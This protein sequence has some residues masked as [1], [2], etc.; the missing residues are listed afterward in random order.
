[1]SRS[2]IDKPSV[3][4][5]ADHE[6]ITPPHKLRRAMSTV[7]K[8]ADDPVARAERAL[9]NVSD[10]FAGW[11]EDECVRL[12]RARNAVKEIG[13]GRVSVEDAAVASEWGPADDFESYHWHGETFAI[14]PEGTRI[15]SSAQCANHVAVR[16]QRADCWHGLIG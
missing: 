1:M 15:W 4:T 10:K 5:F 8:Y 6:V 16:I 13:W 12:D 9:A 3:A 11:M 7:T 2:K 14:P